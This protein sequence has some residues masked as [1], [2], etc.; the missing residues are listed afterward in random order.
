MAGF[1]NRI[2]RPAARAHKPFFLQVTPTAAHGQDINRLRGKPGPDPAGGAPPRPL[3]TP[4][5]GRR[6]WR[7]GPGGASQVLPGDHRGRPRRGRCETERVLRT[8]IFLTNR[9]DA[10]AVVD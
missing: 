1:A 7:T 6:P 5:A 9:E 3:R 2:L 8:G 10:E 4:P